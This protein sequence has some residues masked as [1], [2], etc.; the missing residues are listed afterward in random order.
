MKVEV[1]RNLHNGMLSIRDAKT[2]HVVGHADRVTLSDVSFHVSESGRQRVLRERKKNVH[3]VVR[4]NLLTYMF[5]GGFKG[6]SLTPYIK[7]NGEQFAMS[8]TQVK[9]NP[10]KYDSFM[11]DDAPIHSA[12][13]VRVGI[14]GIHLGTLS[15]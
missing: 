12:E 10:Y 5:G 2:K 13:A 8:D 1:Y 7:Y 14:A 9:Y 15:Q 6:R 3:A 4:G 11:A